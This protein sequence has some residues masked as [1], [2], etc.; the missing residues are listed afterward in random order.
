VRL[1]RRV[2]S[3]SLVAS[4]YE[5]PDDTVRAACS[6]SLLETNTRTRAGFN[7]RALDD[8][9]AAGGDALDEAVCGVVVHLSGGVRA[10]HLTLGVPC[11]GDTVAV[12]FL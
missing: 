8:V 10:V 5:V 1:A 7:L 9:L 12:H 4:R 11:V 2:M 6:R 3:G